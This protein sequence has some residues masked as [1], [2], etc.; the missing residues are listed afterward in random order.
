M[1]QPA[2]LA[3][4]SCTARC[5]KQ[6]RRRQRCT[7]LA[8]LACACIRQHYLQHT[9]VS[10]PEHPGNTHCSHHH[11]HHLCYHNHHTNWAS[12][13]RALL[14][15]QTALYC[16]CGPSPPCLLPNS[17]V[18]LLSHARGRDWYSALAASNIQT[19]SHTAT[20]GSTLPGLQ[21]KQRSTCL[22]AC[23]PLLVVQLLPKNWA[24]PGPAPQVAHRTTH[25]HLHWPAGHQ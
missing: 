20:A 2:A 5:V 15:V 7:C 6:A 19:H 13:L 16:H 25:F 21:S 24:V 1:T 12:A 10:R 22:P 8:H 11:Y 3:S 4:G 18:A 17:A 9:S 23:L 14:T